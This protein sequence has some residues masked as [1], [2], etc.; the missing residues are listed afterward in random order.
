MQSKID[1]ESSLAEKQ[2]NSGIRESLPAVGTMKTGRRLL[3]MAK[4]DTTLSVGTTATITSQKRKS[5]INI[6]V[7][8][9]TR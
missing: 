2:M 7:K 9:L 8:G 3:Q 1:R 5:S 6:I 4:R